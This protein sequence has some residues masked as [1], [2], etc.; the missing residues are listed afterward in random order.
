MHSCMAQCGDHVL[1][2]TPPLAAACRGGCGPPGGIALVYML[3]PTDQGKSL[4]NNK[5]YIP[6]PLMEN[7]FKAPIYPIPHTPLANQ[8][9][10]VLCPFKAFCG[11]F[12]L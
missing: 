1:S 7:A 11:G 10:P 12:I 4:C 2:L 3:T 6:I 5:V 9:K 8:I